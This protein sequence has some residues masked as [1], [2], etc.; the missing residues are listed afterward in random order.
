MIRVRVITVIGCLV[1]ELHGEAERE[2]VLGA[3]L[4]KL[5]QI[6][7]TGDGAKYSLGI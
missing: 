6:L 2:V 5:F 4:A 3:D 1:G 7:D